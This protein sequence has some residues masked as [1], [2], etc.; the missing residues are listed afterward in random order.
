ME[1][2]SPYPRAK[3]GPQSAKL[4]SLSQFS[5][6]YQPQQKW[7]LWMINQ[8]ALQFLSHTGL[9]RPFWH[10]IL[11][12]NRIAQVQVLLLYT[13]NYVFSWVCFHIWIRK[14]F[15]QSFTPATESIHN[16]LLLERKKYACKK[17][18]RD[19]C[20]GNECLL[21]EPAR[22]GWWVACKLSCR[23]VVSL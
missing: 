12:R 15:K 16:M 17:L 3:F 11:K 19:P 6:V 9:C 5:A 21:I 4:N 7:Y 8:E 23:P 2:Q 18:H 1:F 14:K 10:D 13:K 20:T 22:G